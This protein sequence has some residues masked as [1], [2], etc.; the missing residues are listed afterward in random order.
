V[1]TTTG[2]GWNGPTG[3]LVGGLPPLIGGFG[4]IGVGE[5]LLIGGDVVGLKSIGLSVS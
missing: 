5:G 2:R 1:G 4:A 3:G